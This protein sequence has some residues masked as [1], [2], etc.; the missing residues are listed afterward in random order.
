[1]TAVCSTRGIDVARSI[2][3]DQVIDYSH[4][5]FTRLD[6]KFDVVLDI[7][8]TRGFWACRRV[9]SPKGIIVV[10][11]G[12]KTSRML[13]PIGHVIKMRLGG[14]FGRRKTAFF[15]AKFNKPDM[16]VLREMLESG[17]IKPVID[18]RYT[19]EDIVEA[20]RYMEDGH[21]QGKVVVTP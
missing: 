1:M 19:I 9:V 3:A 15:I 18:K 16:E 21:P 12:P 7:A 20:F 10:V 5:D 6:R 8:G 13:G 11:G 14:L 4:E 17:K 2:G